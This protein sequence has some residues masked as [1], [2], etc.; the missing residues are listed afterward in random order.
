MASIHWYHWLEPSAVSSPSD[1]LG[2]VREAACAGE[3]LVLDCLCL[4]FQALGSE[5][6]R[7]HEHSHQKAALRTFPRSSFRQSM[8]LTLL[9]ECLAIY[10]TLFD[11]FSVISVIS[12]LAPMRAGKM[13][14]PSP[15]LT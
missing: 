9:N 12:G 5:Y 15:M 3:D 11:F 13:V 7:F 10:C 4:V 6:R 8:G 2:Y 1:F 14:S